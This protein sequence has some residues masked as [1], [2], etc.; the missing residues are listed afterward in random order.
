LTDF[1]GAV[2]VWTLR[3]YD[4]PEPIILSVGEDAE[5]SIGDVARGIA[6]AMDFRGPVVF[7]ASK[8][9]G[10]FKKT[11]CNAKLMRLRPETTFTPIDEGLQR[12]CDW[13]VANYNHARRGDHLH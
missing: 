11:A 6:R 1:C 2:Q 10:Q 5:V 8:S 7:D 12:A 3:E 13:F 9:D 4:S